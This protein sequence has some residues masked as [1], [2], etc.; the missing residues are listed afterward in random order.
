MITLEL[1]TI[2][3]GMIVAALNVGDL[4]LGEGAT[5]G[6]GREPSGFEAEGERWDFSSRWGWPFDGFSVGL[7]EDIVVVRS[8]E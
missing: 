6:E 4:G 8:K 5:A 7:E 3:M 1:R 2:Q